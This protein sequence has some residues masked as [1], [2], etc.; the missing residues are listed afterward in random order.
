LYEGMASRIEGARKIIEKYGGREVVLS[1]PN[2]L[3][4]VVNEFKE[5]LGRCSIAKELGIPEWY[6][7]RILREGPKAAEEFVRRLET[8]R[9]EE[10]GSRRERLERQHELAEAYRTINQ[11]LDDDAKFK[12]ILQSRRDLTRKIAYL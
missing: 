4:K 7:R 9:V 5:D 1:D 11:V 6:V 3:Y 2:R 8:G 10:P 12:Q